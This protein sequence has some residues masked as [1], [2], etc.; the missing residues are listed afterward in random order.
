[1]IIKICYSFS[2]HKSIELSKTVQV[3]AGHG[4]WSPWWKIWF[5][6]FSYWN[7]ME[8]LGKPLKASPCDEITTISSYFWR[9]YIYISY[10]LHCIPILPPNWLINWIYNL[11]KNMPM[12]SWFLWSSKPTINHI[13]YTG[14]EKTQCLSIGSPL[15]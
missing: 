2:H 11:R 14:I 5:I 10:L 13:R 1:M 7:S 3:V 12:K 4:S 8:P 9:L 15:H 6:R